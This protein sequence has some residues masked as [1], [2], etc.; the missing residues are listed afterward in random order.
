M[1]INITH[2]GNKYSS[3]E[4]ELNPVIPLSSMSFGYETQKIGCNPRNVEKIVPNF[5]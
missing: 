2:L 1:W 5:A 3:A 4:L